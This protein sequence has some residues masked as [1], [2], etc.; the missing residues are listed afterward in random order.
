MNHRQERLGKLIREEL[1]KIIVRELE[2]PGT[3]VTI[4]S[5]TITDKLDFARVKVSVWPSEKAREALKTLALAKRDL[6]Y[7]LMKK[8]R[9][10]TIPHL[11][12]EI[13]HGNENAANVEKALMEE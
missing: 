7:A 13:D 8:I 1:S 2:F 3:V 4:A 11:G 10:K 12:F 9:I 6:Q 5:V